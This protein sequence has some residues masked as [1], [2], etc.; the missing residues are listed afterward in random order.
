MAIYII[1]KPSTDR[2]R[3]HPGKYCNLII[4]IGRRKFE[5]LNILDFFL[6]IS[7]K[8]LEYEPIFGAV[9]LPCLYL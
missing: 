1:V 8:I 2:V 5:T 6:Q 4:I 9:F 7:W 3:T